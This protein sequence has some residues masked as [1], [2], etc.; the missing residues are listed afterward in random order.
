MAGLVESAALS[1]GNGRNPLGGEV[2]MSMRGRKDYW[3]WKRREARVECL[4]HYLRGDRALGPKLKPPTPVHVT[5][6]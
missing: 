4:F 2:V 1:E 6:H 5:S 3:Q